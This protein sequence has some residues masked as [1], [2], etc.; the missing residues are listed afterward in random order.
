MKAPQVYSHNTSWDWGSV[1]LAEVTG[2]H[3]LSQWTQWAQQT[4][5]LFPSC[6]RLPPLLLLLFLHLS[7]FLCFLP[8][9]AISLPLAANLF[10]VKYVKS[11]CIPRL[12]PSVTVFKLKRWQQIWL[13][14]E[15]GEE[16]GGRVEACDKRQKNL[17]K[18]TTRNSNWDRMKEHRLNH[19][20]VFQTDWSPSHHLL[21]SYRKNSVESPR[22]PVSHLATSTL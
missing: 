3:L 7:L 1:F 15:R 13:L 17:I 4:P 19:L 12:N 16:S 9:S 5:A 8:S 10:V 18:N 20:S 22:N 14:G 6:W 21:E 2:A 11:E